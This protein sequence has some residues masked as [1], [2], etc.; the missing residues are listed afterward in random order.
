MKL[1][2]QTL[3]C[4]DYIYYTLIKF[5]SGKI[6]SYIKFQGVV[7]KRR[8]LQDDDES[9]YKKYFPTFPCKFEFSWFSRRKKSLSRPL[10]DVTNKHIHNCQS[11]YFIPIDRFQNWQFWKFFIVIVT[12]ML[13]TLYSL[14]F[15]RSK[16]TVP[17]QGIKRRRSWTFVHSL[18]RNFVWQSSQFP[19]RKKR[20]TLVRNA[21][22]MIDATV[23]VTAGQLM[24]KEFR[25]LR[26]TSYDIMAA[27]T[28]ALFR[29][30][31]ATRRAATTHSND[32]NGLAQIRL[33]VFIPRG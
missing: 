11:G 21:W 4:I 9:S 27:R 32:I 6:K 8:N 29:L 24:P 14:I 13:F 17:D 12:A 26:V 7:V 15:L 25:G 19:R 18:R 3:R 10:P 20:Q 22:L 16:S 30:M 5:S 28:A 23:M 2:I 33:C 31:P 1:K